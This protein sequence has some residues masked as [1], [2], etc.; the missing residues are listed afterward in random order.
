M[1][2]Y[3]R[4]IFIGQSIFHAVT[5]PLR[6]LR[7]VSGHAPGGGRP[8]FVLIR[9][10]PPDVVIGGIACLH[11]FCPFLGELIVF[12]QAILIGA[13]PDIVPGNGYR[14]DVIGRKPI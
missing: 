6:R 11:I 5:G 2:L 8:H 3:V 4:Y 14:R 10:Y 9:L 1:K 12:A 7:I 13:E